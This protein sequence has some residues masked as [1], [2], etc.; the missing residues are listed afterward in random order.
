MQHYMLFVFYKAGKGEQGL[1]Q[2]VKHMHYICDDLGSIPNYY[3]L[4]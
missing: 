4:I 2:V 3:Y 1:D